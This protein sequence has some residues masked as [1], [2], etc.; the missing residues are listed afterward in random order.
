MKNK[1]IQFGLYALVPILVV[2]GLIGGVFLF[3]ALL[4]IVALA[5]LAGFAF[6]AYARLKMRQAGIDPGPLSGAGDGDDS[7]HNTGRRRPAIT[8]EE[9]SIIRDDNGE[10]VV[11]RGVERK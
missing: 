8:I 9:A 5:G 1:L 6:V 10:T 7:D 4:F 3:L 11:I 2:I